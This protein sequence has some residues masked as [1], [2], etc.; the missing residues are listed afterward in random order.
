MCIWS[1]RYP[2]CNAHAPYCDLWPARLYSIFPHYLNKRHDIRKKLLN[3]KCVFWLSVQLLSETFLILR[4]TERD[5]IKNV[6]WIHVKW[7]SFLSDLNETWVVSIDFR[8]ILK[9]QLLWNSVKWEPRF[10]MRTDGRTYKTKLIIAFRDFANA[11]ENCTIALV[12][13]YNRNV[14]SVLAFSVR[15]AAGNRKVALL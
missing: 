3:K 15:S 2:T 14:T 5:V 11:P 12:H 7:P 6:N 10:S 4:R 8:K 1:L 13:C 9:Y